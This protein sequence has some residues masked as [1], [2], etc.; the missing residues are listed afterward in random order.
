MRV[1]HIHSGNMYGGVETLLTTLALHRDLAPDMDAHFALC[2]EQRLSAELT[3]SGVPVHLLGNVRISRLLTVVRTRRALTK[4]LRCIPFDLAI[5]HSAWSQALFG[6]TVRAAEIPLVFWLHGEANGRHWLERWA[7]KTPPDLALCNSKFTA[8]TLPNIYPH[9][10]TEVVYCPVTP[11]ERGESSADRAATRAELQTP[12]NA[13]VI[14]QVSRME[15]WKGHALH[16]EALSLLK[17]LPGWV[18]WQ[19]GGAQKPGELEYFAE[20]KKTAIRLGIGDRVHFLGQR[21]D[22]PKLL[23]AANIHCQPNSGPEPFGIAF[24]EALHARLPVVTTAI[25]GAC[26]IVDESCGLLVPP[27]DAEALAASLRRLI[28]D[29]NLR[30]SLGASGPLRAQ[31]LCDPATQI[32]RL[33]RLLAS[34]ARR[35]IVN[36]NV[37]QEVTG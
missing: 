18:C 10:R 30:R 12:E 8:Q 5:C 6:P 32:E 28:E 24:I 13:V 26:E 29:E 37:Q 33:G 11:P 25:G 7:G 31:E 22:V 21:S 27:G 1:L 19:V 14:I 23:A 17:D 16:L 3:A 35:P 34:V 2:F 15:S 4:L 20:L 9:V 36:S